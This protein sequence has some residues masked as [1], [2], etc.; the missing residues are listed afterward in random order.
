MH[1]IDTMTRA[2]ADVMA[3]T[4]RSTAS[5]SSDAFSGDPTLNAI[6]GGTAGGA[7]LA[8]LFPIDTTKTQ[9]QARGTSATTTIKALITSEAPL[10]RIYRGLAPAIAEHAA[11]RA[12]LFG[13]G[14]E[15]KKH[16]PREWPEPARDMASGAA[17]AFAKTTMLHPLDTIKCRWQVGLPFYQVSGLYSGLVPAQLRS[18]VGMGIWLSS[19]NQLE[20]SLPDEGRFWS[21][22]KP[23]IVGALSSALTD[24]L[25]YPLDTLKKR[26]QAEVVVVHAGGS[27][28]GEAA[29]AAAG[30]GGGAAALAMP[31]T[32]G[33]GGV[34]L[35]GS[36]RRLFAEGG[37]PRFYTGYGMRFLMIAVN[38]ALFN[39]AF[40]AIKS[41]LERVW[42]ERFVL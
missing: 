10:R 39:A 34:S 25:T 20:R 2:T 30:G 33:G 9:M 5:S 36:I 29:A 40:V 31:G 21:L 15:I 7:V 23:F 17:A 18:S 3:S 22:F 13:V 32:G 12:M 11:N 28:G 26:M 8:A 41:R 6:A 24:L 42:P 16:V 27:G 19:R 4:T 37:I 1:F 35:L 38:G 14:A